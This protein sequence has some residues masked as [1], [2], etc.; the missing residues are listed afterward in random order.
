METSGPWLPL[1][2]SPS[3]S[4]GRTRTSG[5]VVS[6]TI[7]PEAPRPMAAARPGRRVEAISPDFSPTINQ[8]KTMS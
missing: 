1:G 8:G 2:S 3:D 6:D 7:A 5:R 4:R